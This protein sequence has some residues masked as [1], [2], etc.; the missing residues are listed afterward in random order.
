MYAEKLRLDGRI[1]VVTGGGR[2]IGLACAEVLCENGAEV[3]IADIDL[4]IAQAGQA[5]LEQKGYTVEVHRL[6]VT[7][8]SEVEALADQIL[9]KHGRVDIL[10]AN[11]GI[12]RSGVGAEEVTD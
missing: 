6:D 5:E 4:A 3:I 9:T 12:A 11:A 8:P 1:A 2:G 7:Q 10:V